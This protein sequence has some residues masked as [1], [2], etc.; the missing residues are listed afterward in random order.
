MNFL[1]HVQVALAVEPHELV[2]LGAVLPDVESLM[3]QRLE[4]ARSRPEVARGIQLHHLAD[5]AFHDDGRF[6]AGWV[7]LSRDLQGRGVGRGASRAVG[8]A[9]WELLLDGT[10]VD[11]PGVT[12][13]FDAAVAALGELAGDDGPSA[14]RLV[15]LAR[16]HAA[17][18]IWQAY[19]DP[20]LVADRLH[21][22]L[23]HRPRLAFPAVELPLVAAGL[24]AA[25]GSVRSTGPGLLADVAA[26]VVDAA[27]ASGT[28]PP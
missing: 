15:E 20:G 25:H 28:L 4:A 17:A 2:A 10:L 1:A 21:R 26:S 14:S 16:R 8:H 13:A 9:G 23:A 24:A 11:E 5:A 6:K 12:D 3:G 7:A 19:G 18:P 27:G 22:Q